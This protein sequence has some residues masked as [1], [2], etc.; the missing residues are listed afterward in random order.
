MKNIIYLNKTIYSDCDNDSYYQ[1]EGWYF[2]D[3]N[4][5]IGGGP[6]KTELEAEECFKEYCIML[7]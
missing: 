5:R 4:D 3:E 2:W 1:G 7:N 6:F